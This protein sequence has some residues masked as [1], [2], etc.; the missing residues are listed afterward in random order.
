LVLNEN[1]ILVFKL[2]TT[3]QAR[4]SAGEQKTSLFKAFYWVI[5]FI[6]DN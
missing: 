1:R 2:S 6:D 3:A 4:A 5:L